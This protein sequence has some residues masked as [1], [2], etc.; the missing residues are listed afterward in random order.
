MIGAMTLANVLTVLRGVLIAPTVIAVLAER[1][2]PAFAVFLC[3]LATDVLDGW[4][5]RRHREV[6]EVGQ[7]LDPTVDKLFYL[8]LF[9]SM[10]AVGKL[11]PMGP[12][13]FLIPQL[14]LGVGT[15]FLWQRREEFVAR[16]PGKAAAGLTALAA[17]LLLVTPY[18]GWAFW[19][20][21][22]TQFS[23]GA[24]YL[25][26]QARGGTRAEA[27]PRTPSTPR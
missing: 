21:V 4:I 18:G 13:L 1:W 11:P 14:G 20:A 2:W 16:W 5:A 6:T 27:G 10:A 22:A 23:A 19:A 12:V 8:G 9:S 26:R 25:A 15:L 7:L 3:A 24:Y 17:A